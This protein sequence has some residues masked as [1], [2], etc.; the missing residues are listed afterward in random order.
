MSVNNKIE[1]NEISFN[2]ILLVMV[3]MYN[4]KSY[5]LG[6]QFFIMNW[7]LSQVI[8]LKNVTCLSTSVYFIKNPMRSY[9]CTTSMNID[10]LIQSYV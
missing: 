10:D 3:V 7:K 2:F 8:A 1:F 9:L 5:I 6:N 4:E